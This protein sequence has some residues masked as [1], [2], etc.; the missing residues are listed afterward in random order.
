[1]TDKP[2]SFE[3][4]DRR[5]PT[6]EKCRDYLVRLRCWPAC[7]VCPR[8]KSRKA[9][10][11]KRGL[12]RCTKCGADISIT[13]RTRFYR[14]GI[15]LHTWFRAAWYVAQKKDGV[16][17]AELQRE[18]GLR[19]ATA[20]TVLR[21][22]R[23]AMAPVGQR[24]LSGTVEMN[25]ITIGPPSRQGSPSK[26]A[27][28]SVFVAAEN[29]EDHTG[30]VRLFR[31]EPFSLK[32][33]VNAVEKH[34][35]PSSV[36]RTFGQVGWG[37]AFEHKGFEYKAVDKSHLKPGEEPL[38]MVAAVERGLT[39]LLQQIYRG[40]VGPE[41]LDRYLDEFAFRFNLRTSPPWSVFY[42]IIKQVMDV[43]W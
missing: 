2:L 35:E 11:T 36:I 38:P 26:H 40:A 32:L 43:G 31:I 30:H 23:E 19:Y 7:F 3:A 4:F 8:C 17:A 18:L 25:E 22:L 34:V 16:S 37:N 14:S 20:W 28:F 6:D 5:F 10:E 27:G 41:G 15:P 1:V 13:A 39:R 21:K 24:C 33:L 12:F 42:R 9:W 29:K